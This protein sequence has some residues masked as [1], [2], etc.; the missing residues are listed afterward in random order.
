MPN[1]AGVR[2]NYAWKRC[3][4]KVYKQKERINIEQK[5]L[6]R[7]RYGDAIK[8]TKKNSVGELK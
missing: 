5:N 6:R 1:V 4:N 2:K 8:I 3:I 7:Y